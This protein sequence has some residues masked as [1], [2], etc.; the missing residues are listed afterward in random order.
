MGEHTPKPLHYI[1][2]N[3]TPI[4]PE[5]QLLDSK[6]LSDFFE[7]RIGL[8]CVGECYAPLNISTK[9]PWDFTLIGFY[10]STDQVSAL[11][12]IT[13]DTEFMGVK[14][15]CEVVKNW[16]IDLYPKD[17]FKKLHL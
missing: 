8:E 15:N 17:P 4:E 11:R 12:R 1:R 5:T 10:K 16:F 6:Q 7:E 3:Q 2:V 14:I 9:Q 13:P